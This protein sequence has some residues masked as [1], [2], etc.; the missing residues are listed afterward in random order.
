MEGLIEI[1]QSVISEYK[2]GIDND[3]IEDEIK[4]KMPKWVDEETEKEEAEDFKVDMKEQTK[5]VLENKDFLSAGSSSFRKRTISNPKE[6][7]PSLE[8]HEL[9]NLQ[10]QEEQLQAQIQINPK[11]S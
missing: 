10:N 1:L 11:Q 7:K 2:Q 4:N 8:T 6:N 3:K 5:T 9:V